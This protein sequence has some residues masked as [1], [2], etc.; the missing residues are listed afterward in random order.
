MTSAPRRPGDMLVL[1]TCGA[2]EPGFRAG[3]PIKSMAHIVDTMPSDMRLRLVTSDR[4]LGDSAPYPDLSGR[5]I[6]RDRASVYYL[7]RRRPAQWVR[8]WRDLRVDRFDVLYVN[9]LFSPVFTV[10]P[11][12]AA[13]LGLVRVGSVVIAPRGELSPGALAQKAAKKRVFLRLWRLLPTA[14]RVVWHSTSDLESQHIREHF[15]TAVVV[16][17][18]NQSGLP[19]RATPPGGPTESPRLVYIGRISPKKNLDLTLQALARVTEPMTLDVFGPVDDESYWMRCQAL[20]AALPEW[21]VVRYRGTLRPEKVRPTFATYDAFVFPTLGENF[22]HVIAESLSSSCPVILSDQTPWTPVLRSG[23]GWV[24]DDLT[25]DALAR[26]ITE[27]CRS[28]ASDRRAARIRAGE[29]FET[30]QSQRSDRRNVFSD[31]R[32]RLNAL[33]LT[34]G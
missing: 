29:A 25:P 11:L 9:S 17:N 14:K 16:L 19:E 15:P 3:G 7:D 5:W 23:G 28:T 2:F 6:V 10:L 21:I 30:W 20:M 31:V 8:L 27:L 32:D 13:V 18:D 12:V 34:D 22:G 1:A 24:L 26:T 33:R 4:D